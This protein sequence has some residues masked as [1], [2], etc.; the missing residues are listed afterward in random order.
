[1][2]PELVRAEAA[3]LR[4]GRFGL[5]GRLW[6]W[7]RTSTGGG[8]RPALRRAGR[9]DDRVRG[10]AVGGVRRG[11]RDLTARS[12]ADDPVGGLLAWAAAIRAGLVHPTPESTRLLEELTVVVS[13]R[14]ELA[15]CGDAFVRA[16]RS[17]AY[18]GPGL[19]G[20]IRGTAEAATDRR[21]A[22]AEAVRMLEEAPHQKIRYQF[23]TEVWKSLIHP[24]G[25]IGRLLAIAAEDDPDAAAAVIA[26]AMRLRS[27]DAINRLIDEHAGRLGAR[28]KNKK[29]IAR[30]HAQLVKKAADALATVTGWATA[31]TQAGGG[32]ADAKDWRLGPL[33]RLQE[34]AGER[35]E[36]VESTLTDL[37]SGSDDPLLAA[38]ADAARG[39]LGRAFDLLSGETFDAPEPP[40]AHVVGRHLL[41]APELPLDPDGLEPRTAPSIDVLVPV[42]LAAAED[43]DAAFEGRAARRDHEGTLGIVTVLEHTDPAAAARG[44]GARRAGRGG[45]RRPGPRDRGRARPGGGVA[46]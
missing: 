46:A 21:N 15:A 42:A 4:T 1:M 14:P 19:A 41:L 40:A 10:G 20:S 28:R 24:D 37:G 44:R 23:A 3:A 11:A 13:A 35:R 18:L 17:G 38:A 5:A 43:W 45:P 34:V 8:A 16:A 2:P 33:G 36:A 7:R 9:R 27:G 39:L 31:V 32:A 30:A 6:T 29:I 22:V 26:E 12:L 25:P